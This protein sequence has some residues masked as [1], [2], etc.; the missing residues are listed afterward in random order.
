MILNF[1]TVSCFLGIQEVALD[2]EEPFIRYPN[3]L[4]L[5]NYQAQY[6]E[7]LISSLYGG[8]HPDA[9][10]DPDDSKGF[11]TSPDCNADSGIETSLTESSGNKGGIKLAGDSHTLNSSISSFSSDTTLTSTC[12]LPRRGSLLNY[13]IPEAESSDS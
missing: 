6:N 2:L 3:D 9:W 11:S 13:S 1:L 7:A 8:F 12:I 5:N 10:G 4:P